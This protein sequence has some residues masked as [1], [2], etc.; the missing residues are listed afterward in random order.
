M[1]LGTSKGSKATCEGQL[2]NGRYLVE[3][4]ISRGGM[5]TVYQGI[6]T[7]IGKKVAVKVL[8]SDLSFRQDIVTR[9]Y[10]EAQAAA[11]IGHRN[12]VDVLD[13][14]LIDDSQP[15]LV[16]EYLEG[17]SL[18]SMLEREKTLNLAAAC[19]I[20]EP[21]LLALSASHEKGVVHR[22]L[23]P[24]NI[25]IGMEGHNDLVVKVI[26]FGISKFAHTL[27]D[28]RLTMAGSAVGTP[29]YMSPEQAR[30]DVDVDYRSD[31]YSAGVIFYEMLSGG[32]PFTGVTVREV[33]AK[34]INDPPTP[35]QMHNQKFP[36][37]ALPILDIA[38]CK[39]P[40]DR[41]VD[42]G[43]MLDDIRQLEAYRDKDISLA[44]AAAGAVKLSCAGVDSSSARHPVFPSAVTPDP[45]SLFATQDSRVTSEVGSVNRM[46]LSKRHGAGV[47]IGVF[48]A[49]AV[50]GV[51][52][53][54][55]LKFSLFE[56]PDELLDKSAEK[57]AST[58]P[59]SEKAESVS[60][61]V[62]GVPEGADVY[63]DGNR[64]AS[65]TFHIPPNQDA[66]SLRVVRDGYE[67]FEV[68]LVP[69]KD[70]VLNVQLK[71]IQKADMS[72]MGSTETKK[73]IPRK[74][75]KSPSVGVDRAKKETD[76]SKKGRHGAT[77]ADDF[78]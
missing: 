20:M 34:V 29:P 21:L 54:L 17:E 56:T 42:A 76:S 39:R 66:K 2:L 78:E 35:P 60:I 67:T 47:L 63:F 22:D 13:V 69:E 53:V 73:D 72:L 43:D 15:Y 16:M 52:S 57:A 27:K 75:G 12:I 6:H 7:L 37:A 31:I 71:P 64:M 5:G 44:A 1:T 62:L 49:F 40:E 46:R 32:L 11:V 36:E 8:N 61:S 25:F 24:D 41:Y 45:L 23:K 74:I 77:I 58:Q 68:L 4:V 55:A 50:F 19:A 18:L 10:R 26:D 70:I 38:L 65:R 28:Q 9:F 3:K 59:V 48:A 30:G 33:L 14:G 51:A